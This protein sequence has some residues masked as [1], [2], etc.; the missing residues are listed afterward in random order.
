MSECWGENMRLEFVCNL[1]QTAIKK[2]EIFTLKQKTYVQV[3]ELR[4]NRSQKQNWY[5]VHFKEHDRYEE[6]KAE[7]IGFISSCAYENASNTQETNRE[8]L[9]VRG[10]LP[11][12]RKTRGILQA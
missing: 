9:F 1:N 11:L 8:N 2:I 12:S 7:F 4:E 6:A 10:S 3:L 5:P